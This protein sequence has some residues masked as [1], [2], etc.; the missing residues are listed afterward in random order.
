MNSIGH[1]DVTFHDGNTVRIEI[2]DNG[3]TNMQSY[4]IDSKAIRNIRST[5]YPENPDEEHF[6]GDAPR[7]RALLTSP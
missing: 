4:Q 3:L 2:W 7:L 6:R 5:F 1:A